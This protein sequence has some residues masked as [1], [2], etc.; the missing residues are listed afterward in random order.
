MIEA[1]EIVGTS[2]P[3]IFEKAI[4]GSTD[5]DKALIALLK[6]DPH[7]N[8]DRL[9]ETLI[10]KDIRGAADLLRSI[11]DRKGGV[12][13]YVC[14][15]VSPRLAH[16]TDG[17][18]AE[19]R[20]LFATTNRP[21]VMIKVPAS[22]DCLPAIIALICEVN[23]VNVTLMFSLQDCINISEAYL[24]SL[25][26]LARLGG[27]LSE[28]AFVASLFVNRIDSDVDKLLSEGTPLC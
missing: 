6:E 21:N 25:E 17:T 3:T 12:D 4:A 26:I 15:E 11:Y 19:A 13:S 16:Y 10:T 28:V 5:Y 24:S 22:S 18:I 7:T 14:V 23:N 9:Y 1:G 2:N 20:R 8:V 27:N